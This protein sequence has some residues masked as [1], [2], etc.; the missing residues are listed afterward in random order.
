MLAGPNFAL[1]ESLRALAPNVAL[2]ASGGIRDRADLE[3]LAGIGC[4]GAVL[5]RSLLEGT[6]SLADALS[7]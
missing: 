2:Q 5:G 3:R 4:A 1:Y 6:L 7:C